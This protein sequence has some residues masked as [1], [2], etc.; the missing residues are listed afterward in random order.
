MKQVKGKTKKKLHH[1]KIETLCIPQRSSARM[2]FG[3]TENQ[4]VQS[5]LGYLSS[6]TPLKTMKLMDGYIY[7]NKKK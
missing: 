5:K 2:G 4:D 6:L 1:K 7:A 3:S